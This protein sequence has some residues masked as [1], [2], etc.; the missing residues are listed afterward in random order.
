MK[1]TVCELS[2]DHRQFEKDWAALTKHSNSNESELVVLS[3]MPF[4][5]WIAN[6]AKVDEKE[7]LNAVEAHQKW[8]GRIHEL[9]NVIVAYSIPWIKNGKFFNSAY[10]WTK[11]EGHQKVHTKHFFSRRRWFL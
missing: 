2:N 11:E 7:K 5:K 9:G 6:V 8:L 10:V 1:V 4:Y 3:E